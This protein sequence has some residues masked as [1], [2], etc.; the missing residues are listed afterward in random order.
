MEGKQC[1]AT[2]WNVSDFNAGEN[3]IVVET[4]ELCYSYF[5]VE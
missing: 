4:L 3:S 5:T 2:Q 1:L